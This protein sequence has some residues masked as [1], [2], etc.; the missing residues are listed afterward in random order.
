MNSKSRLI[1]ALGIA[2]CLFLFPLQSLAEG[3]RY[4][5]INETNFPD[6]HFRNYIIENLHP[7]GNTSTGYY[8]TEAQVKQITRIDVEYCHISSM[9]GI[10]YFTALKELRCGFNNLTSLDVSKNVALRD[11]SCHANL[12]TALNVSGNTELFFLDCGPNQLTALDVSHNPELRYL[13]CWS[14]QLTSMDVSKN[15]ALESLNCGDNKLTKLDVSGN[16]VLRELLCN[17]N[18]LT[19]LDMSNNEALIGLWCYD[20]RLTALDVSKNAALNTLWCYNNQLT[21]LDVSKSTALTE[22]SCFDNKLTVLDIHNSTALIRV[23]CSNN[24]LTA[25]DV[26]NNTA[27]TFINC[28]GNRLT[29]IDVSM[30][31]YLDKLICSDNQL[32][33]LDVSKNTAL[34]ELQC[35]GNRLKT[36]DV[37]KHTSLNKLYCGRNK[38]TT[39]DVSKNTA[40]EWLFCD[41]NQMATLDVSKNTALTVLCCGGNQFTALDVSKNTALSEYKC[42]SNRLTALDVSKNTQLSTLSCSNNQLTTLDVSKNTELKELVCDNNQLASLDLSKNTL[43]LSECK[44]SKQRIPAQ[45]LVQTGKRIYICDLSALLKDP[46]KVTLVTK[47]GTYRKATGVFTFTKPVESFEYQYD[48][49]QGK[50]TVIVPIKG[51][52]AAPPTITQ[53]PKSVTVKSG[54]MAKFAV[55][56]S[57]SGIGYQWYGKAPNAGEWMLLEGETKDTI[58]L[59]ASKANNGTQYRCVVKNTAGETVSNAAT[60]TVTLDVPVIKTQPK[61]ITLKSGAKGKFTVKA[62]GKNLQYKWYSRPNTDAEWSVVV[63]ETKATLNVVG[64]M[65]KNGT[66]Y[67]CVIKNADGEVTSAAVTL[68]VTK[69]IPVIKTQ[70]KNVKVKSGSKGK[71]TV[72]ASGK[73]LSYKW[74][75]RPNADAEWTEIAGETKATLN[76]VGSM[77]KNGWEFCC[78]VQNPDGKVRSNPAKLTV[79]PQAPK[80]STQPK[81]VKAKVGA[82][83][84][85]KVKAS[86]KNVIYQWYYRT[87][88]TGEWIKIEGA[89]SASYSFK[90][91]EAQYGYQFRCYVQNADGEAWSN[92]AT[93][94][95]K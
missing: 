27:T 9:A 23:N 61:S 1:L 62:S 34:K 92:A 4:L 63:G 31:P 84:T 48:T 6:K 55:K 56:V 42:D 66:Q 60:L 77:D 82:K 71:F 79:T 18:Q 13:Y 65:D 20:N 3:D 59:V 47:E 58:A 89:T 67:R 57:G 44:L 36:L 12:L 32:T 40:L 51:A 53:Q 19:T 26:S 88:E 81:D 49:T 83:A 41:Q 5:E 22:L 28:G 73:N 11:L 69:E 8:M 24:Q 85:F 74:F 64:S 95:R 75:S 78:E 52:Q 46:S 72:K 7:S 91:T 37:S 10:G 38:L 54:A 50:M 43:V 90:V 16:P 39:L 87:S 80:I 30:I 93:L 35:D 15:T 76:I 2:L 14:N 33:T 25:L 86:P 70:P 21:A 68:T 29:A 17:G 94:I 45:N